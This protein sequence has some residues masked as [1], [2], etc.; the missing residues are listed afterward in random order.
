[1][2]HKRP[3]LCRRLGDIHLQLR[4][5]VCTQN[6]SVSSTSETISKSLASEKLS[7]NCSHLLSTFHLSGMWR[8]PQWQSSLPSSSMFCP[9]S[10][11][12]SVHGGV[13][14]L[15]QVSDC[16]GRKQLLCHWEVRTVQYLNTNI[17]F[18]WLGSTTSGCWP[19]SSS[20]HLEGCPE[21]DAVGHRASSRRRFCSGQGQWSKWLWHL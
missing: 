8:T 16:S 2:V 18:N 7:Y 6:L 5:R 1:M 21:E 17:E 11:H 20:A 12:V 15:T 19:D 13:I 4:G 9:P 14:V 3:R 10:R